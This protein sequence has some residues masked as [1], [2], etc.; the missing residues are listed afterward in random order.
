MADWSLSSDPTKTRTKIV[1]KP[2]RYFR[3]P[4]LVQV[5]DVL[6]KLAWHR[7]GSSWFPVETLQVAPLWCD[8]GFFQNSSGNKAVVNLHPESKSSQSLSKILQKE[9]KASPFF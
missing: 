3:G 4:Q 5:R 1:S 7:T 9:L 2:S 6:S 8:L